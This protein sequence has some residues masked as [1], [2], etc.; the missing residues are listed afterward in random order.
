[1]PA[2]S[3]PDFVLKSAK[4][5]ADIYGQ[6]VADLLKL[7]AGR[8]ARGIDQPGWAERKLTD[9]IGLRTAAADI[10]A[11]LEVFGPEAVNLAVEQAYAAGSRAGAI[12]V[13][14]RLTPVT[15]TRAVQALAAE[16][17]RAV[18]IAHN[19]ILRQV[20][21]V[22]RQVVSETAAQTI[23]GARTRLAAAQSALNRLA[24]R[25]I[26]TFRDSA[27]RRWALESYAETATRTAVGRAQ[28][29]GALDRYIEAGRDL[30][31]VSDAPQ[32]CKVCRRWEG[33]VLSITGATSTGTKV[34]G[35]DGARFTVAG[36]VAEAQRAGLH[37]PNCRHRLGAFIDGATTRLT[38]TAD[39]EGD[40]AR[41]EQR[42]LERGVRHWRQRSAAA[43]D[44]EARKAA[45]RKAIEWR[46]RLADHVQANDLQRRRERERLGAR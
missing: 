28:V 22:Y 38:D 13:A 6:A 27:G 10:V 37:H 4:T 20:D 30:V 7:V 2:E 1:M 43:M 9:L 29:A 44:P 14:T 26:V 24:D 3:D 15:D 40:Q 23:T 33:K 32:E 19:G 35:G 16:T 41:Q 34:T 42:R 25:G 18:T 45:D 31:I 17:V 46:K 36:T 12:E 39:P 5:V 8:L 21:D 11:R